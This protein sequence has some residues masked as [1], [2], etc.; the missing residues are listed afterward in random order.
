[1]FEGTEGPDRIVGTPEDDIIDSKGGHDE[2][3]GGIG[4]AI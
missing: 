2:N 1:V 3:F 4:W